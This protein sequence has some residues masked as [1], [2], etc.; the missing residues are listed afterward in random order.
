[1]IITK[2]SA[3]RKGFTSMGKT[4]L[5]NRTLGISER[6]VLGTALSR[7]AN[8]RFSISGLAAVLPNGK[9]SIRTSIGKLEAMGYLQREK[10]RTASGCFAGENWRVFTA[11]QNLAK[12]DE[13]F[14]TGMFS[15]SREGQIKI[16]NIVL[17]DSSL[18]ASERGLMI[19]LLS[20]PSDWNCSATGLTRILPDGKSAIN[21]AVVKLEAK[22]YLIRQQNRN[23]KGLFDGEEWTLVPDPQ[24]PVLEEPRTVMPS[25][26]IRA[27]E[28]VTQITS[29][30]EQRE[31]L[32]SKGNVT[33]P[34]SKQSINHSESDD[35]SP[36]TDEENAIWRERVRKQ[37]DYDLL[38]IQLKRKAPAGDLTLLDVAVEAVAILYSKPDALVLS[39]QVFD[40]ALMREQA[41]KMD[42]RRVGYVLFRIW[43]KED[44]IRNLKSYMLRSLLNEK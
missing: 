43:E 33:Y 30:N 26:D 42:A 37:I 11:P 17:Y 4:F 21:A 18:S 14:A 28:N 34:S 3:Y 7:P 35:G 39:K 10:N 22:G 24:G 1:M 32:M 2:K 15:E 40:I 29:L 19:T 6:G 31:G 41:K 20:L 38:R 27:T 13:S 16:D 23:S 36:N 9:D 25:A 8:W 12:K 5:Y 44:Q